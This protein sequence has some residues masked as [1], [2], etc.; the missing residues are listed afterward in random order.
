MKEGRIKSPRKTRPPWKL[1]MNSNSKNAPS[2]LN[3]SSTT[4]EEVTRMRSNRIPPAPKPILW[5][6][7]KRKHLVLITLSYLITTSYPRSRR[8]SRRRDSRAK[9]VKQTTLRKQR[10]LS[11]VLRR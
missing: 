8:E 1:S 2:S 3:C 10:Q 5:K 11:T 9:V 4:V 6:W 7:Y